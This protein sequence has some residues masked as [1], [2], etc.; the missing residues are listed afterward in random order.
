MGGGWVVA[1]VSRGVQEGLQEGPEGGLA[2]GVV[3]LARG[4]SDSATR[5]CRDGSAQ[6]RT[7]QNPAQN[8]AQKPDP[9]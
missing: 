9:I 2:G 7:A 6:A 1:R 8:V 3:S 4:R 5:R